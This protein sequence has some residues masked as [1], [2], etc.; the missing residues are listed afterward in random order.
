MC[1][2]PFLFWGLSRSN[3]SFFMLSIPPLSPF[4]PHKPSFFSLFLLSPLFSSLGDRN[5]TSTSFKHEET[6]QHKFQLESTINGFF[7]LQ[8]GWSREFQHC[9]QQ[10]PFMATFFAAISLPPSKKE[11]VHKTGNRP[12]PLPRKKL[13]SIFHLPEHMLSVFSPILFPRD[14]FYCLPPKKSRGFSQ[15][16]INFSFFPTFLFETSNLFPEKSRS[17]NGGKDFPLLLTECDLA[18]RSRSKQNKK[19]LF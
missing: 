9:Q 19:P 12:P 1:T 15:I 5:K 13:N 11:A 4:S 17:K 10:K 14:I 16:P 8:E 7:C 2:S 3:V 18:N 6:S